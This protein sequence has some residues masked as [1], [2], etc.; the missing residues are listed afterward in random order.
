[1]QTPCANKLRPL[2]KEAQPPNGRT[3][4]ILG[5]DSAGVEQAQLS[6]LLHPQP[7][8]SRAPSSSPQWPHCLGLGAAGLSRLAPQ[9]PAG[10][11]GTK[12]PAAPEWEGKERRELPQ[13]GRAG[14]DPLH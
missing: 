7:A 6:C 9:H 4:P 8:V 2:D 14:W 1:M 13:Q 3:A 12:L 10:H 5:S 11:G